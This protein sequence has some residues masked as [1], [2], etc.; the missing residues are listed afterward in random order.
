[1][2]TT[3]LPST[4]FSPLLLQ[5]LSQGKIIPFSYPCCP[6]VFFFFSHYF[7]YVQVFC[8]EHRSYKSHDCPNSD[9]SSRKVAV[10]EI[11]SLAIETTGYGEEEE[12]KILEKHE[13]RG[14]CDPKKKKKTTCPVRRCKEALTFSNT[15]SCKICRIKVCL[16]HRFPADHYCR[17]LRLPSP[18]AAGNNKFWEAFATRSGKDCGNGVTATTT[19]PAVQAS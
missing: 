5:L 11:C 17:N 14:D 16:R 15:S 13:A 12:K 7:R 10:C 9:S 3:R 4:R 18:M 6:N 19:P 1:M 8:L 2:P